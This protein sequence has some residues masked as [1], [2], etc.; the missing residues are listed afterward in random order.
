MKRTVYI[1]GFLVLL[2]FCACVENRAVVNSRA[3][4]SHD[5]RFMR[6]MFY[7]V[8]NL[9]DT[10]D[11][12]LK[13]DE[14]FLPAGER[15]WTDYKYYGKLIRT[16]KV[17]IA[18]GE[19]QAPDIVGLCEIEN[20]NVLDDLVNNTPLSK[21]DYRI[22]HKESPD[23]RG[24]DVALLY[25]KKTFSPLY[26]RAIPVRFPQKPEKTTRD[27]LYIKGLS[28]KSDT[29]H[30]FVN[31]WASRWGGQLE[32]EALRMHTASIVR[33]QVDSL[34][35]K[36]P[37]SNII[38]TG[39]FNDEPENK[40]ISKTLHASHDFTNPQEK[41][42]Y[43]LSYYLKNKKEKGSYKHKGAWGVLDQ[44]IVSGC[45][46]KQHSN[47]YLTPDDCHVFMPDF[48]LEEDTKYTGKKPF[49]TFTGYKY[50]GGFSDHLPVFI[51]LKRR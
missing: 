16:A 25:R 4:T 39:D 5:R 43:N 15:Y 11:D 24:I 22:V 7:N 20:R 18:A 50:N 45:L 47:L 30:I 46:L 8:E 27:I 23:R 19:W 10:Q 31:H 21:L 6:I 17:I 26:F 28:K 3:E 48:L 36:N 42:L 49:R 12:T 9:F 38:I 35:H 14:E 37:K 2:C 33:K 41:E 13:R 40:S 44:F 34:F 1:F 51:D 29:L 32:T